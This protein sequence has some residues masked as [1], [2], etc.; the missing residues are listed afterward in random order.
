MVGGGFRVVKD[1]PPFILAGG[2][3]LQYEGINVIGLRRRGFTSE[4]IDNI[5]NAYELIY[6]S[7]YNFGDAVKKIK[8]TLEMTD[9]VKKITSFIEGSERGIVRG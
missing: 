3:P 1:L 5:K 6:H 8:E 4:Q 7:Q 9:E 2:F